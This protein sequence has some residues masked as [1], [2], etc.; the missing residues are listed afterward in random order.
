MTKQSCTLQ[1]FHRALRAR[2]PLGW[3]FESSDDTLLHLIWQLL[4]WDP[5]E[6]ITASQAL[7]HPY[8]S[9][10]TTLPMEKSD[11]T[12]GEHNALESQMLDP[13]MDF[14]VTDSIDEFRCPQCGRV[15][16]DWKSCHSHANAR[17]HAKFCTYD[18]TTLP[19]CLNAHAMLPAHSSSGYCDIQG[20]RRTIEDFHAI[21]LLPFQQFYGIFDGHLGNF[22]SKYAASFLYDEMTT[23]LPTIP[24]PAEACDESPCN[25]ND[26][27][28][29]KSLVKKSVHESFSSVHEKFL[30]ASRSIPQNRFMM[31]QSGTTATALLVTNASYVIASIGDSR[32]VLSSRKTGAS[33]HNS[34]LYRDDFLAVPLT[35]DH[36]ASNP[37][38]RNLVQSRGGRIVRHKSS[39]VDR[40]NGTLIVTRSIGDAGLAPW[41]SR[42]PDV[43]ILS[44]K[45]I[46]KAC[47]GD[48]MDNSSHPDSDPKRERKRKKHEA[49]SEAGDNTA[50]LVVPCFMILASDGLW[51][52]VSNQE[53]VDLVAQVFVSSSSLLTAGDA[54]DASNSSRSTTTYN[55]DMSIKSI[56]TTATNAAVWQQAAEALTLE[57]YVRGSTDNI[58]VCVVAVDG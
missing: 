2:D 33:N 39:G 51:D 36:V 15:F 10:R 48:D 50:A 40:V 54:A 3:G 38:E 13:R 8:F 6:R 17:K 31:D 16:A 53:A 43:V 56:G 11:P 24:A 42:Q 7:N 22:A 30:Q 57:A 26:Q 35:T 45:E 32:A 14:N 12:P 1:D 23:R 58:G 19:T 52:T 20:R 46:T 4:A 55:E 5:N 28:D 27:G 21:H 9:N 49:D 25:D 47:Y 18:T 29:W 44:R 37:V 41:L 34:Y